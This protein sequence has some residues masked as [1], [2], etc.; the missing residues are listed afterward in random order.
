MNNV[1]FTVF[2]QEALLKT[3][4]HLVIILKT[5]ISVHLVLRIRDEYVWRKE[6]RTNL[7]ASVPNVFKQLSCG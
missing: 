5:D 4:K 6:V 7:F 1:Y 3:Q 2:M